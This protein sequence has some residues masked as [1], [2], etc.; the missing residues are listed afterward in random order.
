MAAIAAPIIIHLWNNRHGKKLKIGSIIFL[1]ENSVQ[2]TKRNFIS[3]WFLLLLRCLLLIL[4]ALLLAQPF[5]KKNEN[6]SEQKG[7][8]MIDKTDAIE[9]YNH[10]KPTIDSLLQKG[11][12]LHAFNKD[13]GKITIEDISKAGNNKPD[14]TIPQYRLLFEA[15]D[16]NA[17]ASI[18]IYILSSNELSKY[19]GEIP[20]TSRSIKWLTYTKPDS[21]SKWIDNAYITSSDSIYLTKT[22]SKPSGT[23]FVQEQI[24]KL[25]VKKSDYE[26][27]VANGN[28]GIG[29]NEQKA[30]I[31]DTSTFRIIIYANHFTNDDEY[32]KAAIGSIQ[33]FTRRKI[34][35]TVADNLRNIPENQ[36]WLFWLS[37]DKIS[38][39]ISSANVFEYNN[40]TAVMM[41]S[42]I[43]L[44]NKNAQ[45]EKISISKYVNSAEQYQS[46]EIIW[47]DGFGKPILLAEKKDEKIVYHFYSHFD[48]A[49]NG[50]VWSNS[51][52]S[53]LMNLFFGKEKFYEDD[54]RI[55]AD[56]QIQ[57]KIKE[58]ISNNIVNTY[59][60]NISLGS[61]LWFFA[62][63][64]FFLERIISFRNKKG[65]ANA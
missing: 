56:Q 55:I 62:F 6:I 9:T 40:G 51:F 12:E 27:M 3:E 10:F 11:F 47:K 38:A 34:R 4:L 20:A 61:F 17:P 26:V 35:L 53:L 1:E 21:E 54:K 48:P 44:N 64:I 7:W 52:P 16:K 37:D 42:W 45:S 63:L 60:E 57:P 13:F 49:W 14:S 25:P 24:E 43:D 30:L 23:R 41:N 65:A 18:P 32:L 15:L 5:F 29:M 36:D 46:P 33:K 22:I 8:L 2:R 31:V 58:T 39:N 50:L 19:K 59:P 28:I